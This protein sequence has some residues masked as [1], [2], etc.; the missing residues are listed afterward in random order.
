VE[1]VKLSKPLEHLDVHGGGLCL[2]VPMPEQIAPDL[3][4]SGSLGSVVSMLG[5]IIESPLRT[6][7][8]VLKDLVRL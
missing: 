6:M 2:K 1:N 3:A 5:A 4:E 7:K 8:V